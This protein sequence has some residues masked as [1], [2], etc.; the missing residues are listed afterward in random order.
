MLSHR[1][2]LLK[3]G[4]VHRV[5][6][7]SILNAKLTGRMKLGWKRCTSNREFHKEW[8]EAGVSASRVSTLAPAHSIKTTS[9][10]FAD[11]D[12]TVLDWPA[13][14]PDL[15]PIWDISKRKIVDPTI[16]T[17]WRLNSASA[18]PQADRFH[19]TPHWCWSLCHLSP[20]QVSSALKNILKRTWTFS[21]FH[22]CIHTHTH[23]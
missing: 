4:A 19:A 1:G 5:L 11:H 22:I 2:S 16:Q 8:N 20:K 21:F 17:S 7:Q 15:N 10:L 13:N 18:V 6:Y 14:M 9:K 3:G 12:I 23:T